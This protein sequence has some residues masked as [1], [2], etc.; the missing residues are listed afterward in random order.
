MLFHSCSFA[1][2]GGEKSDDSRKLVAGCDCQRPKFTRSGN[3]THVLVTLMLLLA[4]TTF[5][6][7]SGSTCCFCLSLLGKPFRCGPCLR[8]RM[9][10]KKKNKLFWFS[11]YSKENVLYS[12]KITFA[13]QCLKMLLILHPVVKNDY[14]NLL[15]QFQMAQISLQWLLPDNPKSVS[16]L[17]WLNAPRSPLNIFILLCPLRRHQGSWMKETVAIEVIPKNLWTYFWNF[18]V[19]NW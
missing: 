4:L 18:V 12:G 1:F 14:E 16:V 17:V 15:Q 6:P 10:N 19:R 7:S 13:L 5:V 8:H 9:T 2:L 3:F 11:F